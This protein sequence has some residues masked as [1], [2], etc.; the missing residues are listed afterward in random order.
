M[1][2]AAAEIRFRLHAPVDASVVDRL[3]GALSG[4]A[5]SV[6]V[7]ADEALGSAPGPSTRFLVVGAGSSADAIADIAAWAA[8]EGVLIVELR[9][10]AASLEDRYLELTGDQAVEAGG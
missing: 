5:G 8:R 6:R 1:A 7:D 9:A 4:A 3:R 10:G 2:T